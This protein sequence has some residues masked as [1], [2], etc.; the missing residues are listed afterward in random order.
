[1]LSRKVTK[2]LTQ[3]DI[4]AIPEFEQGA[5]SVQIENLKDKIIDDR[6]LQKSMQIRYILRRCIHHRIK[7]WIL[8][9]R[10]PGLCLKKISF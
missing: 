6:D 3:A 5:N 9:M 8:D 4:D 2:S 7:V 1:M 10:L